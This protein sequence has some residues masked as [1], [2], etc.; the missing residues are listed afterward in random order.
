MPDESKALVEELHGLGYE[1]DEDGTRTDGGDIPRK[2][3]DKIERQAA[4]LEGLVSVLKEWRQATES[5]CKHL[6]SRGESKLL[7]PDAALV[8]ALE[9]YEAN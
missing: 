5:R 9:R 3:A 7:L 8:E 1:L 4:V 6:D 2:A